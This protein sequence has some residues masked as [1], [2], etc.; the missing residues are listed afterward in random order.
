MCLHIT[1]KD[2]PKYML[3]CLVS[4]SLQ[5]VKLKRN[6]QNICKTSEKALHFKSPYKPQ[7]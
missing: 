1:L 7:V 3:Q 5:A 6:R 2:G 4:Q